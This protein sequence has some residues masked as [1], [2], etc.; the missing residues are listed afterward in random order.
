MENKDVKTPKENPKYTVD[1]HLR[2]TDGEYAFLSK[3]ARQTNCNIS[4]MFRHMAFDNPTVLKKGKDSYEEKRSIELSVKS[5]RESFKKMASMYHEFVENYKKNAV[6]LMENPM[7]QVVLEQS[8]RTAKSLISITLQ[9][10]REVNDFLHEFGQNETH[11]AVRESLNGLPD[12]PESEPAA[13]GTKSN[14]RIYMERISVIGKLESDVVSY[15]ATDGTEKMKARVLVER[16]RGKKTKKVF[17]NVYAVKSKAFDFLKKDKTVYV[18][19]DFDE[20]DEG[21]KKVFADIIKLIE[22]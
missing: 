18:E 15:I 8:V 21:D 10:Q 14:K 11:T 3:K 1:V 17:Y 20:N 12:V 5:V 16:T 13:N 7:S 22:S 6:R 9:A 19:G 4:S 2:L